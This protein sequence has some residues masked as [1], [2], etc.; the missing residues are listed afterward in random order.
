[1][2]NKV[3]YI[4]I[5]F[6][7]G[8]SKT[9]ANCQQINNILSSDSSFQ[10]AINQ[11]A[12]SFHSHDILYNGSE[13]I[14]YNGI[15]VGTPFFS[16]DYYTVGNIEYNGLS[17]SNLFLLYDIVRDALVLLYNMPSGKSVQMELCKERTN[18]F[19]I[20]NHTFV[21]LPNDTISKVPDKP[22][23]Y[24]LLNNGDV[25]V[26]AKRQKI[27]REVIEPT[28]VYIEF[29]Y[30]SDYYVYLKTNYFEVY[31]KRS[32]LNVLKDKK[33]EVRQFMHDSN[34]NYRQDREHAIVEMVKYY[35]NN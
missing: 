9:T 27:K 31:S 5:I 28:K 16:S 18:S 35:S 33:K 14:D 20:N 30:H 32:V 22:G 8:F 25:K 26:F 34:I 3:Y 7:L 12:T 6:I 23:F 11:Y 19:T 21:Y 17:Y 1:M 10:Y 15:I 24:E 4:L 2:K 29:D 13:Y